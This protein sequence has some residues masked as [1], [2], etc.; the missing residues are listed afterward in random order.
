MAVSGSYDFTVNRDQ[1]IERALLKIGVLGE[2][3]TMTAKHIRDG[4]IALNALVQQWQTQEDFSPGLK[5][6]SRKRAYLF[7]QY[8]QSEYNLGP[9]GDHVTYSYVAT[10]T[11]A[12]ASSGASTVDVASITGMASGDNIGILMDANGYH[13]TT[14]NG[15]P[16]GSTVTL[17]TNLAGDAASEARVVVYTSKIQR[18][19]AMVAVTRRD[20][21]GDDFPV[22]KIVT[23]ETYEVITDKDAEGTP[24]GYLYEPQIDDAILYFDLA[25]IDLEDTYRLTVLRPLADFDATNDTPDYPKEWYRALFFNL[26]IDLAPDY[27]RPVTAELAGLAQSSLLLAQKRQSEQTDVYFQPGLE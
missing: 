8:L 27:N 23:V 26:A 17:T 11:T 25:P 10:T 6:W 3:I 13:W 9:S 4:S 21:Y 18:P 2:G 20:K 22:D 1:I 15:A 5:T 7:P 19:N 12:A 14:I 16:S 24:S